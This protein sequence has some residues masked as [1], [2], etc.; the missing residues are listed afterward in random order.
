MTRFL[1]SEDDEAVIVGTNGL[2]AI[3][4]DTAQ[5]VVVGDA[6]P[7]PSDQM[8]L[9]V[10]S[11]GGLDAPQIQITQ[12]TFNDAA[13]LR[14]VSTTRRPPID[15]GGPD[16]YTTRVWDIAAGN[17]LLV[18]W[19]Q[20]QG[21]PPGANYVTVASNGFIGIGTEDPQA[22]LDVVG[23]LRAEVLDISGADI[24]E[25]FGTDEPVEPG[26]VLVIDRE[27]SGRLRVSDREYD[28]AVAGVAAGADGLTSGVNLAAGGG[29]VGLALAG[30]VWCKAEAHALPIRPG[31][32]LTSSG[33]PGHAMRAGDAARASGALLGK[34]LSALATGEGTVLALVSLG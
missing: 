2:Q 10:R 15:P 1:G 5:R 24:A 4:V 27:R 21:G 22:L 19:S 32:P 11:G 29:G 30:R 26:S 14:L 23:T 16:T 25:R 31:D 18:L 9:H 17:D 3:L 13:R 20:V 34:A 12:D 33:L 7:G 6:Q 28:P 8:R